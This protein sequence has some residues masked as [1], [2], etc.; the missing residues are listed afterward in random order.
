MSY[1]GGGMGDY[2]QE[3]TYR[4]VG[5][6]AGEYGAVTIPQGRANY[7]VCIC[8][9]LVAVFVVIP[10]VYFLFSSSSYQDDGKPST[11]PIKQI[12]LYFEFIVLPVVVLAAIGVPL[13]CFFSRPGVQINY[14]I[15]IAVPLVVL[16]PI[17]FLMLSSSSQQGPYYEH[18]GK[19]GIFS[20]MPKWLMLYAEFI[21]LPAAFLLVVIVPMFFCFNGSGMQM[22]S[23]ICITIPFL[24]IIPLFCYFLFASSVKYNKPA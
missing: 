23:C 8:V 4:Y 11:M 14:C 1:V 10:L 21:L 22:N 16:I 24:V 17:A 6:G 2:K 9:P 7:F 12:S 19:G 15:C 18:G 13:Y 5:Y 20:E 3:T